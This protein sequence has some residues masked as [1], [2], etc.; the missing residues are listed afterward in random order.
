MAHLVLFEHRNFHGNHK[1]LFRSIDT[2]DA[3]DDN[4]FNDKTSSFVILEGR[5][6]FFRDSHFSNPASNVFGPGLY[7]W[8]EDHG[9]PNDSISSVKLV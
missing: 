8:V 6:Q 5:W 9:V 4:S 2:L 7:D 1:H 3:G